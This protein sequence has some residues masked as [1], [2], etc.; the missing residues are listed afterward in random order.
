MR[1]I[2]HKN[3]VVWKL[4]QRHG[5]LT[6][7]ACRH[8]NKWRMQ[9]P[10]TVPTQNTHLRRLV[11]H[12]ALIIRRYAED[13]HVQRVRQRYVR[14]IAPV[15]TALRVVGARSRVAAHKLVCAYDSDT[16]IERWRQNVLVKMEG[17][18]GKRRD[19]QR[20]GRDGT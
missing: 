1:Y 8:N 12:S 16:E 6:S 4:E 15:T 13:A 7:N 2:Y 9:T 5:Q 3:T 11:H 19:E 17:G 18:S 10:G 14:E 20:E